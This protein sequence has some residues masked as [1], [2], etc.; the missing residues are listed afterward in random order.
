[1]VH[2]F[3]IFEDQFAVLAFRVKMEKVLVTHCCPVFHMDNQVIP[4]PFIKVNRFRRSI[5][6]HNA[7]LG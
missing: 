3:V 1:M 5:Y 2:A 4:L 7:C 6:S